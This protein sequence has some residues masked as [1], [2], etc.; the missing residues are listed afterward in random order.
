MTARQS[1]NQLSNLSFALRIIRV[2]P[3]HPFIGGNLTVSCLTEVNKKDLIYH[4]IDLVLKSP[5]TAGQQDRVEVSERRLKRG[6]DE[7]FRVIE[8]FAS[9]C[10]SPGETS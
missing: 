6:R 5:N 1:S 4:G 3:R 8:R 2:E 9:L 7:N 10:F